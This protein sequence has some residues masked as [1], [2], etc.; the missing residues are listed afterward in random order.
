MD[1]NLVALYETKRQAFLL[2]YVQ[3]PQKFSAA[4]AFAVYH[5]VS[6]IF[7]EDIAREVHGV[8]PFEDLYAV[9]RDFILEVLNYVDQRSLEND[10][11]ALGFYQLENKFGGYKANR[12]ELIHSLE[13]M[14]ID[15]RF[16][17]KVWSAIQADAPAEA[18]SLDDSFSP[19]DVYFS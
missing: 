17:E 9:K 12:M 13:Y 6:P 18:N 11:E 7:H 1:N 5:R 14:R 8:D 10:F 15:G 19:E 16:D 3:F 2:G 4:H